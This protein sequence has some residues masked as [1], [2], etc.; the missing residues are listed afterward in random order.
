MTDDRLLKLAEE[1]HIHSDKKAYELVGS[2]FRDGNNGLTIQ[3]ILMTGSVMA[4]S[5][6]EMEKSKFLDGCSKLYDAYKDFGQEMDK[7][8][9]RIKKQ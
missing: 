2:L 4:A 7:L 5:I 9:D 1:I 3:T 8:A 6:N